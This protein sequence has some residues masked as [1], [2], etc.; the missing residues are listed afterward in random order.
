MKLSLAISREPRPLQ[1]V[2]TAFRFI[3][4]FRTKVSYCCF[5]FNYPLEH[6]SGDLGNMTEWRFGNYRWQF[7]LDFPLNVLRRN[8]FSDQPSILIYLEGVLKL[9][10]TD[11]LDFQLSDLNI[12]SLDRHFSEQTCS[13]SNNLWEGDLSWKS[14]EPNMWLLVNHMKPTNTLYWN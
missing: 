11:S 13:N 5:P 10:P 6:G 9:Y 2:P 7:C 12:Y 4:Y 3:R 14:P 8:D 1:Y